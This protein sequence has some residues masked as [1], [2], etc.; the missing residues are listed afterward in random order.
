MQSN[1]VGNYTSDNKIGQSRSGNTIRLS[2]VRLRTVYWTTQSHTNNSFREKKELLI[3]KGREKV[4]S[5][6][7]K[8]VIG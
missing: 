5:N 1:S 3:M 8:V 2:R 4:V 6:E 7:T